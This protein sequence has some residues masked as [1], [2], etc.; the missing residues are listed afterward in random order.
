LLSAYGRRGQPTAAAKRLLEASL[1]DARKQLPPESPQLAGHLASL[2]LSMLQIQ[3]FPEAEPLLR[4]S[5]AIRERHEPED[6]RT[7]NARS[8]LGGALLG[9]KKYADAEALLKK[10]Y[11]GMK[12]R[13]DK[14][15]KSGGGESRVPE[16]I[17]RLV[18]LYITTNKP[19]EVKKYQAER[20]KYPKAPATQD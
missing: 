5:L 20:D 15:P 11:E 19:D 14:I 6:W 3:A 4:E 1:E 9:Q 17:D 10:G 8:M 18:K 2:G 12:A 16:A 13:E 7:Y